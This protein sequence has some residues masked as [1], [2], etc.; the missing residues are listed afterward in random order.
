LLDVPEDEIKEKSHKVV[1]ATFRGMALKGLGQFDEAQAALQWAVDH[2]DPSIGYSHIHS[3]D[4]RRRYWEAWWT[5]RRDDLRIRT[6]FV[7]QPHGTC[8]NTRRAGRRAFGVDAGFRLKAADPLSEDECTWTTMPQ[9]PRDFA[10]LDPLRVFV[11]LRDRTAA[12][13]EQ[14]KEQ[15]AWKRPFSLAPE[16]YLSA[17]PAVITAAEEDGTLHALDPATGKTL[18]TRQVKTSPWTSDSSALKR[19]LLRQAGGVVLVPDQRQTT[20]LE[21]V[22]AATGNSLWTVRGIDRLSEVAVGQGLVVLGGPPGHVRALERGTGK[23]VFEVDLCPELKEKHDRVALALDPA[24]RHVYAAVRHRVWALDA[25]A[26]R[27]LWRWTWQVRKATNPPRSDYPPA[28][29]LYPA[30]DGLFALFNW[31]EPHRGF[32]PPDH[33]D[34]VRFTADGTVALHETSPH[35]RWHMDAFVAGNRLAILGGTTQWEVWEFLPAAPQHVPG[36]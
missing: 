24:G 26:G 30:E 23:P 3:S 13:F 28:P 15:P 12:L 9:S 1:V 20:Q 25:A 34:V 14:G 10:A 27:T 7:W 8:G 11:A 32:P 35:L 19:A 18:W 22:D 17:G 4:I 6:V 16:S 36:R 21:C 2:L 5:P 31:S 33:V 29:R